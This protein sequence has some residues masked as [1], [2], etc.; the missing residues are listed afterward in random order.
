MPGKHKNSTI[1]FRPNSWERAII[2][3]KAALSG[4]YKKDFIA[5]S[6]INAGITIEGHQENIQRIVDALH[7]MQTEMKGIA[8][9]I[10]SGDFSLSDE[11]YQ[12]LK[13]D[14]LALVV[15][16]VDIID[17]VAY[18]FEN[19]PP[20]VRRKLKAQMEIEQLQRV[21]QMDEEGS[22]EKRKEKKAKK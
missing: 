13:E 14:Y 16:V 1:S 17:G 3:Q 9:Q 7:D 8:R 15:A 19:E 20:A 5:Q 21:L 18:T 4:I 2:E 6:C 11:N 12:E 10:E 22:M